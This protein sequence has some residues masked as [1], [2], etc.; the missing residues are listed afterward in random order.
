MPGA[1][2][3]TEHFFQLTGEH[4]EDLYQDLDVYLEE[5]LDLDEY[6]EDPVSVEL[7]RVVHLLD[8]RRRRR[9]HGHPT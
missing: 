8:V 7:A 4:L 2:R 1:Y 5:D 9:C 6:L 3:F